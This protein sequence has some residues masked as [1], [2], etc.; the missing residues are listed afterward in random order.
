MR[1]A[2]INGRILLESGWATD[3][4]VLIDG[5]RIV[6]IVG[7]DEVAQDC[8]TYDLAGG[9]LMPGFIDVQVNGGGGILFNDACSLAELDSL[10]RAHRAYGTTGLMPTLISDDLEVIAAALEL[11]AQAIAAG[12]PGILGIHVEGPFLSPD[13]RGVHDVSKFR[14]LDEPAFALL[15]SLR[16]GKA[17]VT[18]AP[19]MTT[20]AMIRRLTDAGIVV[21]AGHTNATH[22]DIAAAL[23]AGVRGFTHLFNAMSPL[24]SREPGTVGAA[25]EDIH[26]WCGL[27]LDGHHVHPVTLRLALRCKP[28]NRFM[29]VTDAMPTVG[30]NVDTFMLQ[31]RTIT[32]RDGMCLD[33]AGTLAGSNL[34][35]AAAVKNAVEM[36][37]IDL[38]RAVRMASEYPA[39][40]LGLDGELGKIAVGY[41]ASLVLADEGLNVRATWIDGSLQV[42]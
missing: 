31:G 34:N 27:I 21:S 39:A 22:A 41:R 40:F 11:T 32:V 9:L 38:A 7:L 10:A 25:L 5:E 4:A 6:A 19:E 28:A 24:T 1:T 29:L 2:L 3:R 16:L 35:M 23:K 30:M 36:L 15:T 37:E 14:A 17:L 8:A 42:G 33:E 26:A 20:P 18:L 13:R 12:V